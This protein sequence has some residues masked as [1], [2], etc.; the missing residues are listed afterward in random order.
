MRI[1]HLRAQRKRIDVGNAAVIRQGCLVGDLPVRR[2]GTGDH[3]AQELCFIQSPEISAQGPVRLSDRT[4]QDLD[5]RV[6]DGSLQAGSQK[7]GT[8]R[9]DH[10]AAGLD[11]RIDQSGDIRAGFFQEVS[12]RV[13]LIPEYLLQLHTSKLMRIGPAGYLRRTIMDKRNFQLL[14][15][16]QTKESGKDAPAAFRGRFKDNGLIGLLGSCPGG[17]IIP[18]LLDIRLHLRRTLSQHLL[19]GIEGQIE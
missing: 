7:T 12:F 16:M 2:H 14:Y 10:M 19:P 4:V 3:A 11:H 1:R 15:F 5:F 18:D 9:E 8:G 6:F 13:D 17:K